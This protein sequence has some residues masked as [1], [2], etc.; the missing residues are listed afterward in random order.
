MLNTSNVNVGQFGALF[1]LLVDDQVYAQP[2]VVANVLIGGGYHN[3][4]YVATV[5]NT[6]YAFDGD[7]G[8]LYWKKNFTRAGW[9]PPTATDMTGACGGGYN[10][11][12]G[13]IGIVGTPVIDPA[14]QVIYFVARSTTGTAYAQSKNLAEYFGA[15]EDA[16]YLSGMAAGAARQGLLSA[17]SR[18]C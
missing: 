18:S 15:G 5:N 2:L 16:I 8:R 9:R 4:V 1:N 11:F 10:N 7:D 14:K 17:V 6:V 12:S 13:N 3:V